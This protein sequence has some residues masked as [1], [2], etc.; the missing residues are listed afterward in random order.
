MHIVNVLHGFAV[1]RIAS[2]KQNGKVVFISK[3]I[4]KIYRFVFHC[5]AS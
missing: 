2:Q 3:I 1:P 5:I 4:I